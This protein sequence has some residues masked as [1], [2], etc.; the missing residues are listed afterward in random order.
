MEPI[1]PPDIGPSR[2]RKWPRPSPIGLIAGAVDTLGLLR[3]GN[4]CEYN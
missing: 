3:E 2:Y 1:G 4:V